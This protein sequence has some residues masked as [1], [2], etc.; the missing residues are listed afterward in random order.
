MTDE[1]IYG[2]LKSEKIHT[3]IKPFHDFIVHRV[4]WWD[5]LLFGDHE[6]EWH[7]IKSRLPF[8]IILVY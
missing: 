5:V 2:C 3:A 8:L 6:S 7:L 1:H 4:I